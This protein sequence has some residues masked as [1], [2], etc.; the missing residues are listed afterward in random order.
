M[1]N[2][3]LISKEDLKNLVKNPMW[4]FYGTVFP[5]LLVVI[6]GFLG[7]ESY[8]GDVTAYDYY[9][10]TLIIYAILT[11]G[12]TSANAFMEVAIRKPNMRIIYAP[13]DAKAIY[14]SKIFSSFVFSSGCHL[15]DMIL[16]CSIYHIHVSAIPQIMIL[17]GLTELFS[18][19][20]GVMFCCIFKTEAMANQ[21]LSIVIN[22][23][24]ILGGLLFPIDGYGKIARTIS[25]LSPAKWLVKAT[26]AMIYDNNFRWFYYA[27]IGLILATAAVFIVCDKTF[28]K[29]DCIC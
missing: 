9:G 3:Y 5:I 6:L 28:R 19:G 7:K 21:I 4:L 18:V 23:F 15:F 2:L 12:M 22:L 13:G 24:A 1:R 16:L 14:L 17:F 11:S 20:L 25:Y 8:G 27:V 26:F 10:I 29:E